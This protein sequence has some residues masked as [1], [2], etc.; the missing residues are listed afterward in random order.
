MATVQRDVEDKVETL[1]E[2]LQAA[3]LLRAFLECSDTIQASIREM[4]DIL[5]DPE[6]DEVD[7]EMTLFTLAEALFPSR[8]EGK[9]GVDLAE[10]ERLDAEQSEEMRAAVRCLDEEE[11][12]FSKLVRQAMKERGM[13]QTQLAEKLGIGQPAVSNILN[14]KA[15]PQRRTVQRFAEALGMTPEA[16]W[17]GF[18]S[19]K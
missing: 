11:A 19:Q 4:L 5:S 1:G 18:D 10:S 17:P 14:R 15:R 2:A 9:L 3:K 8:H 6:T 7:Y 12:A 13:T 16:L